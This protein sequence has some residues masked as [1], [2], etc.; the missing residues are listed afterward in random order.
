MEYIQEVI[1]APFN[2]IKEAVGLKQKIL[3]LIYV[4][5]NFNC[6]TALKELFKHFTL[7][8]LGEV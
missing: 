2:N 8:G 4:R 3:F 6:L 1:R 5:Y 7:H